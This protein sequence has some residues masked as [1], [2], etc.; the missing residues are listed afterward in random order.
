MNKGDPCYVVIER[1]ENS[2]RYFAGWPAS[3]RAVRAKFSELLPMNQVSVYLGE[4]PVAVGI[5]RVFADQQDAVDCCEDLLFDRLDQAVLRVNF[6]RGDL[7]G[8]RKAIRESAP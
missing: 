8:F 5:F 6:I 2:P 7:Y 4:H 3:V 1:S